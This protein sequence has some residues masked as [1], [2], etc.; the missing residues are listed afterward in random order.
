M[1]QKTERL[2]RSAAFENKNSDLEQRLEKKLNDV[3]SFHN[4]INNI[5][6]M[7]TYVKEK[8]HT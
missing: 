8:N 4:H 3:H 7:I 5:K 6:E 1:E 2:Y